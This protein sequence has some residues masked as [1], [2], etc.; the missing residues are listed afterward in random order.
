MTQPLLE[1]IQNPEDLRNL[2]ELQLPQLADELREFLVE[3]LSR[4]GGHF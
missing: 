1:Q 4:T 3:T 2:S